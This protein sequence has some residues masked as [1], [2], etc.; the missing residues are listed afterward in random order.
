MGELKGVGGQEEFEK[1]RA[2]SAVAVEKAVEVE[3]EAEPEAK[4]NV[5]AGLPVGRLKNIP[6]SSVSSRSEAV[7]MDRIR[8]RNKQT[9]KIK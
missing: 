8:K 6:S 5:D 4:V 3:V 2:E 1:V 7:I 9:N